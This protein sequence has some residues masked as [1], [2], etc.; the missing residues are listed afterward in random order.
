MS[1]G[2][3]DRLGEGSVERIPW[4]CRWVCASISWLCCMST[5]SPKCLRKSAPRIGFC[6][7]VMMKIQGSDRLSLRLRVSDFFLYVWIGV[8]FTAMRVSERRRSAGE[9]GMALTSDPVSMRKCVC[10]LQSLTKNWQ[11]REGPGTPVTA[12]IRPGS[13]PN[14]MGP[15]TSGQLH[16]TCRGT[17]RGSL[18]EEGYVRKDSEGDEAWRYI[19]MVRSDFQQCDKVSQACDFLRKI[20]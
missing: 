3:M 10:V 20:V 12:S 5:S 17:S 4:M 6:T 7:S 15:C 1:F 18:Q 2:R 11:L 19:T 14:C 16:R 13:F 8:S 9:G